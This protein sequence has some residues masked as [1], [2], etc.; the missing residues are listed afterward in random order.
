MCY[1][2]FIEGKHDAIKFQAEILKAATKNMT[3]VTLRLSSGMIG[4]DKNN[5]PHILRLKK[6]K[7]AVLHQVFAVVHGRI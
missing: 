7:V 4:T 3:G 6:R 5:F 1:M 2:N